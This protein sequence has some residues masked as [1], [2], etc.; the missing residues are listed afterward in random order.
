MCTKNINTE[1][2]AGSKK[3]SAN[4]GE[5]RAKIENLFLTTFEL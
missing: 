3:K 1:V 5:C 2:G 4:D